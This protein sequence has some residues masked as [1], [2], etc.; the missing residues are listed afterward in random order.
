MLT[1]QPIADNVLMIDITGKLKPEHIEDAI[2]A[3]E[4]IRSDHET[5]S[6]LLDLSG[7]AGMTPAAFMTDLRYGLGHFSELEHYERIAVI[8]QHKWI[9]RIVAIENALF[10]SIDMRSFSPNERQK[11]E[12]FARGQLIDTSPAEPHIKRIPTSRESLVALRVTGK[13]EQDDATAVVAILQ[14]AFALHDNVDLL[15]LVDSKLI[16]DPTTLLSA[17]IWRTEW[18]AMKH[19]GR[20]AIVAAPKLMGTIAEHIGRL[21]PV[22]I[23]TF[24]ADEIDDAW[25]WLAARPV[26][27][28]A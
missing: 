23:K 3:L 18:D 24:A 22:E 12:H 14:N 13:L 19:V 26:E 20:Y 7:Y 6:L 8:T 21:T 15:V 5:I 25:A 10:R 27:A 17:D 4:A 9:A 11:A 28:A 1:A 16:F 2:V